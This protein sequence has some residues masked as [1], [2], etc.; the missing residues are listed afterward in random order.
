[1][2]E[3]SLSASPI[4]T[5]LKQ[6]DL[7][8]V[9]GKGGTGKS[10]LVAALAKMAARTR[11]RALAVEFSAHPHLPQMLEGAGAV[12]AV[13]IDAEQVVGAALGRLLGLP[14]LAGA[15][16]SNRVLRLFIR[17]SPAIREMIALDE[18]R[19]LVDTSSKEG[20]P[21]IA[22]LPAT[23]HALSFL[24]TPRAV[25]NML[26]VGPLAQ[27]ARRVEELLLDPSRSELVA[28]A[29]P[30]EL[31]VN[32]TIELMRRA[33][34]IGVGSGTVVVNQVPSSPMSAVDQ[35]LLEALQC[36]ADGALAR[37]AGSAWS[38]LE[39][40]DQ[41][42]A[43]VERLRAAVGARVIEVPRYFVPDPRA[44][45]DTLARALAS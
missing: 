12:R 19:H 18:L 38:D 16:L 15:V 7:V 45:V 26:R 20:F 5:L 24:D 1:M 4:A 43:Q 35:P 36:Q 9:T 37:F 10:T 17:T 41:A 42:R 13:N 34:E 27:V 28:V 2:F 31:P 29:L 22:D 39:G 30:E 25:H 33:A 21:V 11:G 8:L 3:S 14:A 6:R 32:E 23:G 40:A 44:C